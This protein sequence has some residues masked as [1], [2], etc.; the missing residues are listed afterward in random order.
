MQPLK[1]REGWLCEAVGVLGKKIPELSL[2]LRGMKE[3]FFW[4]VFVSFFPTLIVPTEA[5]IDKTNYN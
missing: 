2:F 1:K 3:N 5:E 4:L